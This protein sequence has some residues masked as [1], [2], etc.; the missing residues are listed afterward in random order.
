MSERLF[1]HIRVWT[2]R[3]TLRFAKVKR[4][5]YW[6]ISAAAC[7]YFTGCAEL[8]LMRSRPIF[9]GPVAQAVR[10]SMPGGLSNCTPAVSES[11]FVP[12]P[13]PQTASPESCD[14]VCSCGTTSCAPA[15][16]TACR[17]RL[18][19]L[20]RPIDGTGEYEPPP[21]PVST[22]PHQP[23]FHLVTSQP[24]FTQRGPYAIGPYQ[25]NPH[26]P[27][28]RSDISASNHRY[29]GSIGPAS[30]D[31]WILPA[32]QIHTQWTATAAQN[33]SAVR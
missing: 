13:M 18:G 15:R 8:Q 7:L 30:R 20:R 24:V 14:S 3:R 29:I 25:P 11:P 4:A 19:V 9:N 33:G 23:K 2:R 27:G 16:R 26:S 5:V 28:G 12:V 6:V 1:P 31:S 22:V 32:A 17:G 10:A 21:P